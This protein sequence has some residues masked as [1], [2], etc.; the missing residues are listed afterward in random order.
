M[1]PWPYLIIFLTLS[2]S[3]SAEVHLLASG[4]MKGLSDEGFSAQLKD[5][6]IH[7]NTEDNSIV[8]TQYPYSL[9][10]SS[11]EDLNTILAQGEF[12]AP[13]AD[14][15]PSLSDSRALEVQSLV[16]NLS[17]LS[18][19]RQGL[20]LELNQR[21]GCHLL[22]S[23][24]EDSQQNLSQ[25][26]E[27]PCRD[28]MPATSAADFC[29]FD[30]QTLRD[31]ACYSKRL[32]LTSPSLVAPK[33]AFYDLVAL[34]MQESLSQAVIFPCAACSNF[35][36]HQCQ[37][38]PNEK[39]RKRIYQKLL[40]GEPVEI[41]GHSDVNDFLS[42]HRAEM[43]EYI[44]RRA[45]EYAGKM[46]RY[47]KPEQGPRGRMHAW[48][49]DNDDLIA[50]L[51][52]LQ[53]QLQVRGQ[54]TQQVLRSSDPTKNHE[55]VSIDKIENIFQ[56]GTYSG[57]RIHFARP[58]G[59]RGFY[60][61][62][63]Q[64]SVDKL[65]DENNQ[66]IVLNDP[67]NVTRHLPP[68][69]RGFPVFSSNS[70]EKERNEYCRPLLSFKD[71][72]ASR[73][74]RV[75]GIQN[76]TWWIRVLKYPFRLVYHAGDRVIRSRTT[77]SVVNLARREFSNSAL[78][79]LLAAH[80]ASMDLGRLMT[81]PIDAAYAET[82]RIELCTSNLIYNAFGQ[83]TTAM[84]ALASVN[85]LLHVGVIIDDQYETRD[86][87]MQGSSGSLLNA[88]SQDDVYCHKLSIR[89]NEPEPVVLERLRCLNE[90]FGNNMEYSLFGYNCGGYTRDI[91]EAAGLSYP[92]FVNMMIGSNINTRSAQD[93]QN[94][95]NAKEYCENHLR[96]SRLM[97]NSLENN[98]ATE[99]LLGAYEEHLRH[100]PDNTGGYS[101]TFYHPGHD[102]ILQLMVS[103][104]KTNV[105]EIRNRVGGFLNEIRANA[106]SRDGDSSKAVFN[107]R[108]GAIFFA[109]YVDEKGIKPQYK[110]HLQRI[111]GELSPEQINNLAPEAKALYEV[112]KLD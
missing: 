18:M 4:W 56:N 3:A 8:V 88:R 98:N 92:P 48:N 79:P 64:S 35:D 6:S 62:N 54:I 83:D 5:T 97:I 19:V 60:T 39:Q 69:R 38:R 32:G 43:E 68:K 34:K 50:N 59:T 10:L 103:A 13:S 72:A 87:L 105:T 12:V 11:S 9:E 106:T 25:L 90:V 63:G 89:S 111:Y 27:A 1:R 82:S 80:N 24:E 75:W 53:S 112:L 29:S 77:N 21:P 40:Q 45:H 26:F 67:F 16:M 93:T 66:P 107:L 73:L 84:R 37:T 44:Q 41:E 71:G 91:L 47:K 14:Q 95:A 46:Q 31:Q 17:S 109:P 42:S 58:D 61:Y 85:P 7:F 57:K 108:D 65:L 100:P 70:F 22:T 104:A 86:S 101:G 81:V 78:N 94:L 23:G 102:M 33:A 15:F 2:L 55:A 36:C 52:K 74:S 99:Q 30:H 110:R 51:D 76:E 96:L 49:Q 20:E 28:I